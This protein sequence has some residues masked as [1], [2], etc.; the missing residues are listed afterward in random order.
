MSLLVDPP[1]APAPSG[2]E[3]GVIDDA[4]RRQRARRRRTAAL[5][6]VVGIGAL[7]AIVLGGGGSGTAP[8]P[9]GEHIFTAGTHARRAPVP[10]GASLT[11]NLTGGAYGWC[12]TL[13]GGGSC[14]IV[15]TD[16][17]ELDGGLVGSEPRKDAEVLTLLLGPQAVAVLVDGRRVPA[18]TIASLPYH[19]RVATITISRPRAPAGHTGNGAPASPGPPTPQPLLAVDAHGHILRST[20]ASAGEPSVRTIWWKGPTALPKGPCQIHAHGVPGLLPE[21]GHVAASIAPYPEP[22][23]GRAFFSCID[24][25]YYLHNWPLDAA[26]LLDA[27]HPGV[28]PAAIP[29]LERLRGAPAI[30]NGPGDGFHGPE[31]AVRKGDA[32]LIVAGGSG[33]AQRIDVLEH[34]SASVAL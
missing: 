19:L 22:I 15:P 18:V 23:I 9:R 21:W 25:E 2:P 11:P 29:G 27:Q 30:Y 12:L 6:V 32:W 13:D 28:I 33:L 31:T 26:I 3:Q 7:A 10:R 14:P 16:G 1:E 5:M 24:T 4:R 8:R 20:H 34:L 17:S